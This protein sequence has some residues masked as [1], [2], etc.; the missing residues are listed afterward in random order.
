VDGRSGEEDRR[1]G[2]KHVAL[3]VRS[4]GKKTGTRDDPHDV[5]GTRAPGQDDPLVGCNVQAL[6]DLDRV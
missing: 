1:S 2:A 5:V 6:C 3:K 4:G